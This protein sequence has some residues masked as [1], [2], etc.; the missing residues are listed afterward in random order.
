MPSC[1]DISAIRETS[2]RRRVRVGTGPRS[3]ERSMNRD[4]VAGGGLGALA[5]GTTIGE[6]RGGR[7]RWSR[8]LSLRSSLSELI[9]DSA[10][11]CPWLLIVD[12][13]DTVI[14]F[15]R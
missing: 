4:R 8:V 12:C 2:D 5:G 6:E 14:E 7:G 3:G 10:T 13:E 1:I 15:G 11:M 9:G